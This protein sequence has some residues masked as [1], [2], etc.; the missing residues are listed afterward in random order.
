MK[1]IAKAPVRDPDGSQEEIRW[2]FPQNGAR[3]VCV[4]D[5]KEGLIVEDVAH[6][7]E[8]NEEVLRRIVAEIGRLSLSTRGNVSANLQAS[9][10]M[11]Q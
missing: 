4:E 2:W 8:G 5:R 7:G 1:R 11:P 6:N 3:T 10:T 9:D